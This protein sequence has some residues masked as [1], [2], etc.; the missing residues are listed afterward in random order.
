MPN[1]LIR[2]Y[3]D[4]DVAESG[5]LQFL[6]AV[7]GIATAAQEKHVW[8]DKG[9]TTSADTATEV[10]FWALSRDVGETEYSLDDD[11]ARD[12]WLEMRM[13]ASAGTGIVNQVTAWTPLGKA[14]KLYSGDIPSNCTRHAEFR[15][16]APASAGTVS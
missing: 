15:M 7:G 8:N 10:E 14:K 5:E 3:N 11:A 9:G 13:I 2:W 6:D 4:D 12:G 1:P 16:V